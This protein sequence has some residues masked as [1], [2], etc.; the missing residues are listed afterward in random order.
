MSAKVRARR[1]IGSFTYKTQF[2]AVF[3]CFIFCHQRTS[4]LVDIFSSVLN[5]QGCA[6][7]PF[8]E[9]ISFRKHVKP[10][11]H[12]TVLIGGVAFLSGSLVGPWQFFML[13][14]FEW[15]EI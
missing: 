12:G 6:S 8:E 3:L 7:L 5:Y 11:F 9:L 10:V 2:F 14:R 13:Q 15:D 4:G 1:V